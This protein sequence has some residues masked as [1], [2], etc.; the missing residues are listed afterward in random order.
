MEHQIKMHCFSGRKCVPTPLISILSKL[1]LYGSKRGVNP[2]M[3]VTVVFV[4]V[5]FVAMV[6]MF[7]AIPM[8]VVVVIM[9]S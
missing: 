4:A 2:T 6:F 3:L 9:V 1:D 7:V 8:V 5:V